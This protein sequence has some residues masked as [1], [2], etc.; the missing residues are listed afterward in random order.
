MYKSLGILERM[1]GAFFINRIGNTYLIL[2]S[3]SYYMLWKHTCIY[4]CLEV[5][6]ILGNHERMDDITIF[7]QLQTSLTYI[8]LYVSLQTSFDF[9]F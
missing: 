2:S 1:K 8:F 7:I 5:K 4:P 6:S 9:Q 3:M